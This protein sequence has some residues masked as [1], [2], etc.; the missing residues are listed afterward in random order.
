MNKKDFTKYIDKQL[1]G[2]CLEQQAAELY[3]IKDKYIPELI[4][5]RLKK[6]NLWVE[7]EMKDKY[8]CCRECGRYSLLK[9][10]KQESQTEIRTETTYI[11]AGYGD[12]DMMGEVEYLV[13]YITCPLCGKKQEKSK[14]YKRKIREWNVR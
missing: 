1:E 7:P 3:K 9:K 14:Y 4:Q 10:C 12:D 8:L 2:K 11:D 13:F 5:K 6:L